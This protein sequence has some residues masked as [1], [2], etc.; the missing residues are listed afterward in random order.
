MDWLNTIDANTTVLVP[1]RGLQSTL[2]KYFANQQIA[3]GASAWA[4]PN[5]MVWDDYLEKLWQANKQGLDKPYMRL[6]TEQAFLIWQQIILQS[7]REDEE[8]TLLNEQQTAN[9]VQRSWKLLHKWRV[10]LADIA[11]HED[12]D[13]RMFV[14]WAEAYEARL[15]DKNWIDLVQLEH[16]LVEKTSDL[17]A[18]PQTLVFAY[19]DL[20]TASQTAHLEAC[21]QRG[22]A[23]ERQTFTN[24]Q[25]NL[26]YQA[27]SHKQHELSDVLYSARA[28]L[29]KNPD[30]KIGIVIPTLSEQRHQVEQLARAI[31]YPSYSPLEAQQ[32][33]LAYRFSLGKALSDVAYVRA[34]LTALSLMKPRFR[35]QDISFLL[36]CHWWPYQQQHLHETILLE[37]FNL[38]DL[39]R[40]HRIVATTLS[41]LDGFCA[42]FFSVIRI[43]DK[44]QTAG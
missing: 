20:V 27:Y 39:G 25:Q 9:V 5:I 12:A 29:E 33:D 6:S 38:V 8:L 31:F 2:V 17:Y 23:V 7:K 43:F 4:T 3:A 41:R 21:Q 16:L 26:R 1:T 32:S 18:L 22:I 42:V 14:Q 10:G 35:Y 37:R 24:Q 34:M 28:C 44:P 36:R 40:S 30:A 11:Q 15:R 13:S 19:F